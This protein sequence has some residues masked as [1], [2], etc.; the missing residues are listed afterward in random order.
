MWSQLTQ[1]LQRRALRIG[2]AVG[3]MAGGHMQSC[4]VDV[5]LGIVEE[6]VRAEGFQERPLVA[7]AEEQRFIQ[8]HTP[9]AQRADH[10][11]VRGRR[12]CRHQSGADRRILARG[13]HGLQGVQGRQE[14]A[15]R[16][17][18]ERLAGV[19]ALIIGIFPV[20]LAW[21]AEILGIQ[22]PTNLVFFVSIAILFLVALQ[23]SSE[24][25]QLES[26]TRTLAEQVALLELRIRELE[27]KRKK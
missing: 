18:A 5:V 12:A 8:A 13:E 26:K 17:T 9:L 3:H 22:I 4:A 25:T 14:I 15:E 7:A 11:L 21:A 10:A 27:G 20:T 6:D 24:L 1:L 19:L 2:Y 23:S 16:A